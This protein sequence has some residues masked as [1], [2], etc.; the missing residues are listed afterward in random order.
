MYVSLWNALTAYLENAKKKSQ[1][2]VCRTYVPWENVKL[3]KLK[4]V[5]ILTTSWKN[6]FPAIRTTCAYA[7]ISYSVQ[8]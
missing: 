2:C 8:L 4:A 5:A 3:F 1:L 7:P 6:K